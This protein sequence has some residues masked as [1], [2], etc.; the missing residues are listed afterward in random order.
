M[1]IF[2]VFDFPEAR[3]AAETFKA[4]TKAKADGTLDKYF[5]GQFVPKNK[6]TNLFGKVIGD[7]TGWYW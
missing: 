2:V 1:K 6:S 7:L 5:D 3:N 4:Y